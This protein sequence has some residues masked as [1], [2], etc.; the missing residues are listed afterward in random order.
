M[1]L[2]NIVAKK[3]FSEKVIRSFV[4]KKNMKQKLEV[5]NL[6]KLNEKTF[7]TILTKKMNLNKGQVV[8]FHSSVN[9]LHLD[10]PAINVINIILNQ[11]IVI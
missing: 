5:S 6:P 4:K 9:N 2:V 8:F 11:F 10:F 3:I 7:R 1:N